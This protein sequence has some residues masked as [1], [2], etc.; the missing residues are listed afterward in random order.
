MTGYDGARDVVVI[1]AGILGAA[2][3][4]R[5]AAR[6]RRV[7]LIDRG[8]PGGGA[9]SHSFAWINAGAKEPIGYHNLNRRS[10]EMW[11]RFAAALGD[12]G[13]PDNV[14]LRWGGKA[15]W[16]R[17]PD[18]AAALIA[19]VRQLQ[20]WGYPT[21]LIDA[22]ELAELEPALDIGPALGVVA[23]EYSANEGQVEPQLVVDAAL[24]RLSER[25][26]G[27]MSGTA[28]TGFVSGGDGSSGGNR[29]V[30]VRTTAGDVVADTVVLAAGTDT[31][32][33]AALAGVNVPQAESPGVVIRT[34]P[35]PRLLHN[36][37]IVYA[38]PLG[39]GRREIHM[40]QCADGRLMIGEGDQESLAE[41]DSQAHADDLLARAAEYLPGLAGGGGDSGAGGVASDAAGRVSGDGVCGGGA[42][43]VCCVD[44]QRGYAGAG[45]ERAGGVGDLRRGAGGCGVRGVPAG[46][47]C[48]DDGGDGG[49]DG[50]SAGGAAVAV[51]D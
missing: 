27:V 48:G 4:W 35:L 5:I 14:G 49:G 21:R 3:A 44:A 39:D 13:D 37:P 18:A 24:R 33:L 23:A 40:R 9:S 22:V 12:D 2:I 29:I 25:E 43:F 41:D 11:P 26:A 6:G 50:A 45:V 51:K 34:T 10:L 46:T 15:A 38:P 32:A 7:A 28:V 20:S 17:A 1:G 36:V 8:E 31:T 30:A 16:E 19:R 47:V 42:E